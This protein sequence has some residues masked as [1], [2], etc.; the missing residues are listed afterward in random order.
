MVIRLVL[1]RALGCDRLVLMRAHGCVWMPVGLVG[2][3][4]SGRLGH[5]LGLHACVIIWDGCVWVL[6]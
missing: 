3:A 2:T 1:M 6:L 5:C 4:V